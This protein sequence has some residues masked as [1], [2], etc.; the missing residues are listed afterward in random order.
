LVPAAFAVVSIHSNFKIDTA[1]RK[2]V[3]ESLT[4]HDEKHVVPTPVWDKGRKKRRNGIS[5]L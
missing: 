1:G 2:I 5:G 3:T 4:Q